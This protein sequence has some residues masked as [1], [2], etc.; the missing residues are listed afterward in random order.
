MQA[1]ALFAFQAS[2]AQHRFEVLK[3]VSTVF[4]IW[5]DGH[6]AQREVSTKLI[7]Y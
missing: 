6:Y 4:L 7:N 1:F 2:V 5:S 3:H